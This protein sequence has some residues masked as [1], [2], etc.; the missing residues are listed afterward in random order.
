MEKEC[1]EQSKE[2]FNVYKDIGSGLNTKRKGLWRLIRDARAGKFSYMAINYKDRL[3][4]FGY[5]YIEKY[6]D[7]FG[8]TI[9]CLNTLDDK[10][11]E[12]ESPLHGNFVIFHG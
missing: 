9:L 1:K 7:E 5:K 6:L 11:P 4:R 10:A 8:V 2:I 3:T 12:S